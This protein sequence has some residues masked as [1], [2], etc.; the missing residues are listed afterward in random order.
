MA[1]AK[2]LPQIDPNYARS[3]LEMARYARVETKKIGDDA[4]KREITPK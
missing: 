3:F 4:R 2:G 1:A